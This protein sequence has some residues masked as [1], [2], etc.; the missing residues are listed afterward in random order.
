MLPHLNIFQNRFN[1]FQEKVEKHNFI[2]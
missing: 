2:I 1:T